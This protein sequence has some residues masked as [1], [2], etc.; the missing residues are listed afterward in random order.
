MAKKNKFYV[1]W[2]GNNPGIYESWKECELQIKG[3]PNARYK[4]F[5][6]LSE[7]EE[8]FGGGV[9]NYIGKKKVVKKRLDPLLREK[10][11][12]IPSWSVDA[13]CSG[14][15]G[16]MEY[17]GV[18][19]ADGAQIFHMG[20]F[21]RGTN[22]IGEFLALVHALA[23]LKKQGDANMPIYSD[24]KIAMGWVRKK[25]CNTKLTK[26]RQNEQLFE[27]IHRAEKWL[28]ANSFSNKLIK[29]DTKG[30]GEIPADFGRK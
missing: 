22:N 17:Q 6:T 23:L 1:V 15:P 11:V 9:G 8:A 10:E 28:H 7:A 30:W 24:S 18:W 4:G 3:Y 25:K 16:V 20:P 14:N 2:A 27:L 13:A 26:T 29:W 21:K 12:I 5:P 19:T